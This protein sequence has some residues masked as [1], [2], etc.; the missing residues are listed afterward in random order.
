MLWLV[1]RVFFGQLR[2]PRTD[3]A[4]GVRD[5]CTREIA[6]VVPLAVLVVWIGLYPNYFLSRMAP[7]LNAATDVVTQSTPAA[8][9]DV[10]RAF[11]GTNVGAHQ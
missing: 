6:A 1:K 4:H 9:N 7:S 5:L 8:V 10:A 2:E 3:D 11:G